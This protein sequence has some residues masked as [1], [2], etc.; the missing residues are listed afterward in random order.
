MVAYSHFIMDTH[1][2]NKDKR[3]RVAGAWE[4]VGH[5]SS[6]VGVSDAIEIKIKRKIYGGGTTSVTHVF[7]LESVAHNFFDSR[8][9]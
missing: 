2:I 7:F 6:L 1:A 3:T 8:A 4:K 9:L 5:A